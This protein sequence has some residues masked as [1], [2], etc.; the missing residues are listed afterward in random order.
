MLANEPSMTVTDCFVRYQPQLTALPIENAQQELS[1][2]L[3]HVLDC[4]PLELFL[5]RQRQL[6]ASQQQ[7]LAALIE[8]RLQHQP[9]QWLL[10][11]TEFYGLRLLV[12]PG[13]FIP[14]PETEVLVDAVYHA[15]VA[16]Q[17]QALRILDI[18]TGTGAIAI[19]L[20]HL[21]PQANV[22]ASDINPLALELASANAAA[23]GLGIHF[24]KG[25]LLADLAETSFDV[26]A[27]NPPYLPK[28]DIGL[29]S[30]EVGHDPAEALYSGDDGLDLARQ[31]VALATQHL[32]SGGLLAL[33]LDPRNVQVLASTLTDW[34]NVRVL[35]D[36]AGRE[37]FMLANKAK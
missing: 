11:D 34:Y 8:Q 5:E 3:A 12:K 36:L 31:I 18:G 9:L 21:F 33:E 29:L 19:T 28:S 10:G 15:L 26:I 13:V 27:S 30:P 2:L 35:S 4:S 7:E 37:R 25:Y 17:H 16:Q 32:R 23:L 14:R 24:V 20:K 22:W 1:W 6:S